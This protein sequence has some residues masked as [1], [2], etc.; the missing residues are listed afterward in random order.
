MDIIFLEPHQLIGMQ[1][2]PPLHSP[3][4]FAEYKRKFTA[5]EQVEP[6]MV[7]PSQ[8]V[9]E[10]LKKSAERFE[11]YRKDLEQFLEA[12]PSAAY[13]M[14][15]GKHRSAAA[16]ILGVKIPCLVVNNDA[17]VGYVQMLM[18]DGKITGVPSVGKDFTETLS[19]L[20]DHYFEKKAFWTMEE[21]T[22]AMLDRGDILP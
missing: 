8:T 2:Y 7:V 14:L 5:G 21:K 6:V 1:D 22:K 3:E 15:G 19:E 18:A 16:T 13:F 9:L 12:H 17:D 11:S 10:H 20:D 4:A